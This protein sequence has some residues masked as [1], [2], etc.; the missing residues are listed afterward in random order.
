[1]TAE[2]G[3]ARAA[4][5]E[6]GMSES[7]EEAARWMEAAI[8]APR[9]GVDGESLG[10]ELAALGALLHGVEWELDLRAR[11]LESQGVLERTGYSGQGYGGYQLTAARKRELEG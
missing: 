3:K 2:L 9:E 8:C 6:R 1:M 11:W 5:R 4:L 10:R 7:L